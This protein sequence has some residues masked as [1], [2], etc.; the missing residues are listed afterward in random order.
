[1]VTAGGYILHVPDDRSDFLLYEA[2]HGRV[3]LLDKAL[4]FGARARPRP[5]PRCATPRSHPQIGY[6]DNGI[7][8]LTEQMSPSRK[9]EWRTRQAPNDGYN[10]LMLLR[11]HDSRL[12]LSH[13]LTHALS[14]R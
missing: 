5:Q 4:R 12:D 13:A 10:I 9:M 11:L 3:V 7:M 2:E 8:G 14:L 6:P 1:M